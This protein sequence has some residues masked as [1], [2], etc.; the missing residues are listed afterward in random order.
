MHAARAPGVNAYAHA[1]DEPS[2]GPARFDDLLAGIAAEVAAADAAALDADI[3]EVE[4]AARAEAY[5]LD[6]LRA[7]Q[8]V[9]VEVVGGPIVSGLVAL[10]GRDVI[11]LAADDGD[12]VI[13]LWGIAAVVNPVAGTSMTGSL[14]E[15]LGLA[16][17]ARS[18]ARQRSVVRVLRVG[19]VPLDGTIDAVGA[20]H[21]EIAEH[22]PGE[23]RRPEAVRRQVLIPLGAV[24]A[25]RRR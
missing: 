13:P 14:S 23:P 11:V 8:R 10:V 17:V 4:R 3:A 24:S 15:R 9:T 1:V 20:D 12:W 22:D 21:L 5:L 25:I 16:S 2:S 7:Q 19:G 18:W 6:R